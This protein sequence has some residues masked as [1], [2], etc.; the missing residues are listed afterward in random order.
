MIEGDFRPPWYLRPALLQSML[1]SSGFRNPRHTAIAAVEEE[2]IVDA[3]GG[4]RLQGFISRRREGAPKGLVILLHG[5]EGSARSAY[6]LSA[7]EYLYARGYDV[8]RL[9]YRDHGD[10]HHL[11]EGL[12]LGTL[13]DENFAAVRYA[14]GLGERSFL[15]G[16]SLGGSFAARMAAR[17]AEEPVAGL[18]HIV[19][20]NPPLDPLAS[21]RV[22]DR[23]HI[24]RAYFLRKWKRSL[25]R[26]QELFP[27]RYDFSDMLGMDTCM[28][29]TEALVRRYSDYAGAADYFGRYTLTAGCLDRAAVPL[30]VL[31][32]A[33]DPVV[34][35]AD[36]R[37]VKTNRYSRIIMQPY[38]GHCGYIDGPRLGSWYQGEFERWFDKQR[39]GAGFAL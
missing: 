39:T 24:I 36:F 13:I 17:C 3:G 18:R 32:S 30:T 27:D 22:I 11:N 15:V 23:T 29:M 34:P 25:R 21:T 9:N 6:V 38:G 33:D 19:A 7:G 20:I 2:L 12:F 14:A 10:S 16:F 28:E 31:M 37:S 4:V 1:N 5:W 8:F 35:A 26:K